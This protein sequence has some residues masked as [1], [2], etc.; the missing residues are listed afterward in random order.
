MK[1][2][3]KILLI[4]VLVLMTLLLIVEAGTRTYLYIQSCFLQSCESSFW[5]TPPVTLREEE[6]L[7]E[8]SRYDPILGYAPQEDVQV[9]MPD[10]I[11]NWYGATVRIDAMGF[12]QN[13]EQS[14]LETKPHIL[15]AGDSFAFGAQVGDEQTWGACL[16]RRTGLGV[17]NA[18]VW[19]Y[20]TAQSLLR[21]ET[22]LSEQALQP[23]LIIISSL[24]GG[25]FERDRYDFRGGHTRTAVV[26]GNS[27][28]LEFSQPP[29]RNTVGS[30]YADKGL[31]QALRK[32]PIEIAYDALWIARLGIDRV[33]PQYMSAKKFRL[34][35]LHKNAASKQEIIDWTLNR[36]ARRSDNVL[37]LLQYAGPPFV[38]EPVDSEREYLRNKLTELQIPFIDTY[39]AIFEDGGN[40]EKLYI[41]H[42]SP[43]GN[44]LVCRTILQSKVFQ[45]LTRHLR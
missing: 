44:V 28:H 10:S 11:P 13:G 3:L 5:N 4:N 39:R 43:A 1:Q 24:V 12:R 7:P 31:E 9:E 2:S 16:E 45:T 37:F 32:Q 22:I 38:G 19:G 29:A 40:L 21:V 17:L 14:S 23:G 18:G 33:A 25:D 30:R 15:I 41:G 35:R 20:G 27:G 36:I 26:R 42:H 34:T 8:M 6:I